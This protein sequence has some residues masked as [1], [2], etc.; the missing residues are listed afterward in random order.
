M[1]QKSKAAEMVTAIKK[2][3]KLDVSLLGADDSPCTVTEW[4]PTGCLALDVITGGGS[5]VG[6]MM[7]IYGDP[8][9]GKSLIAAQLAAEAQAAGNIVAYIDTESAVSKGFF[10]K[11]GVKVDELIYYAPDTVEEVFEFCDTAINIKQS[12]DPDGYMLLIWDSV[13]ATSSIVEMEKKY[14]DIGYPDQARKIS[15]SLRKITRKFSHERIAA[16]FINQTR[17]KLGVMFGDSDTTFGGNAI[18]FH[19]SVR[20]ALKLS[21]KLTREKEYGKGKRIVGLNTHA[22]VVKNKVSIPFRE[23]VL[24]IYF[25]SGIDDA[26]SAYAWLCDNGFILGEKSKT[27]V[28]GDEELTFK[29]SEWPKIF[30]EYYEDIAN[31]MYDTIDDTF[32]SEE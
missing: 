15:Q 13:A 29:K 24:P 6:R 3:K 28:L 5:P 21:N 30:D 27:I 20:V 14:G 1:K 19:A 2:A 31:M 17:K 9:S 11:I 18:A 32:L 12:I 10:E 16:V 26:G 22:V 23:A 25:G 7:E 8:S 4:I